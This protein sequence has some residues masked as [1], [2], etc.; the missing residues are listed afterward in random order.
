M[1]ILKER[2]EGI[3]GRMIEVCFSHYEK[4][5]YYRLIHYSTKQ[6]DYYGEIRVKSFLSKSI[7]T[8]TF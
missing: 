3:T 4:V 6:N 5:F 1:Q 8:D 7:V 2:D